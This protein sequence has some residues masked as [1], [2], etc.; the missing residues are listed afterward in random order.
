MERA[1]YVIVG[2]GVAGTTAA[3]A[4]RAQDGQGRIVIISEEPYRFYSRIMLSKPEFF[5]GKIPFERI[6]L[7]SREWYAEKRIELWP[8]RTAVRLS[9]TERTITF[10]DGTQFGYD[11]LLLAVGMCAIPWNVR[12]AEKKGVYTLRTLDDA[13]RI[14]DMLPSVSRAV[15]IGGGFISFETSDLLT[16]RGIRT[17][18]II[19]EPYYWQ[20]LL[21]PVSG[22]M[23]EQTLERSGVTI[24]RNTL[25]EE[26]LGAEKV[27]GIRYEKR[28]IDCDCVIVG[29]GSACNLSF[30][31]GSGVFVQRGVV[32]NEYL[33]TSAPGVWAAGDVAMVDDPILE[34]R[35]QMTN[36]VSAQ[37][38]GKLAGR[39][40]TGIREP[41]R[42]ISFYTTQGL[43]LAIAFVGDV[44]I[45]ATKRVIERRPPDQSW[46]VRFIVQGDELV[47]ATLLNRSGDIMAIRQLIERNA[48]VPPIE[49]KLADPSMPLESLFS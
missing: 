29:I 13:K 9:T 7:R 31:E 37:E 12:G 24:V 19:R 10:A 21:D 1:S 41:F 27:T 20:N 44:R 32:T 45:D 18:L 33:E 16:R 30:L 2:G 22:R 47:G 40:M 5:L 4:I 17:T 26:V 23:I 15:L 48:K 14:I 38:Q 43:G 39:N 34:E 46:F 28:E 25:V 11:K 35:V 6:F 3:E 8:H 49:Q 42:F 36:W